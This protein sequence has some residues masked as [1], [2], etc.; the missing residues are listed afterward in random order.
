MLE[1]LS[2]RTVVRFDDPA[3]PEK[4]WEVNSGETICWD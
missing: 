4:R 2:V 3:G 1:E